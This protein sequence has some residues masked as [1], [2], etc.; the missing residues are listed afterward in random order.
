MFV[1]L[2]T[3]TTVDLNQNEIADEGCQYVADI[4][5]NN[6]VKFLFYPYSFYCHFNSIT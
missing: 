2:Q 6:Q 3:I 1:Y 5:R 4:L